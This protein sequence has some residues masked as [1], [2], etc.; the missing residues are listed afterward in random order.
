MKKLYR[1]NNLYLSVILFVALLLAATT[2]AQNTETAKPSAVADTTVK[3]VKPKRGTS[4]GLPDARLNYTPGKI[5]AYWSIATA[6]SIMARY[7]DYREAYWKPWS[8]V[9]G[10]MFYGFEML[11]RTTGD[12]RY[13][14]FIKK[15]IDNFVDEKGNFHGD[16]LNNLDNLMTGSSIVD[17]YGY[18]HA[19]RYKTAATQ[20]R[21]VFD[22]YPRSHDGQ[23]WHGAKS[24]NMW[25]DGVFMG[26]MF[27]IRYGKIIGDSKYCYDEA[28]KQITVCAKHLLKGETGLY[29]HGWTEQPEQAKWADPKT[30]LSPEVWSEGMGWLALVTV[31]LLAEMPN[32]H[33]QYAQIKDIYI[34]L[35][36]GLKR[37]QDKKTG[38]WFMIVDKGD[39]PDNWI[40]PSGTGMF[41]YFIQRGIDI[42]VIRKKEYATVVANGYKSLTSFGQINN[43]G[44]VDVVGGGDGIGIKKDYAT[45]VSYK[46]MTNAKETVGGFLWGTAIVEKPRRSKDS[47]VLPQHHN[48]A[49]ADYTQGKVFILEND[50]IVWQHEAPNSNDLWVLS[51][52]NLLF[53]TG[54]GVLELTRKNDTIFHYESKNEVYAC[55]RLNNGNTFIGECNSGR[56]LEVSPKGKIVKE[57]RILPDSVRDGGHAY[58]RN[59]RRL[60]NG[61]FLVAHYGLKVIREYDE[62]GTMVWEVSVP[63]GPHTAIRLP[64]GNT[65]VSEADAKKDPHVYEFNKEGKIVWEVSNAD[66]PDKPFKFLGGMQ[67]LP[68]GNT[69]IC[70]WLG[71]NNQFGTAPHILEITRDK[72]V[73]WTYS[74]YKDMKTISTFMDMGKLCNADQNEII[75]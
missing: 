46:R 53:T 37:T 26:Q 30:G 43:H 68:N 39:Q 51:N 62:N 2:S 14:D 24:P 48:F 47:S 42:G 64:N 60:D 55:Q 67:R 4:Q 44:L 45:Y 36:N 31:E 35:A 10:Y 58:M 9:H 28:A 25:I 3:A 74:N 56:L 54:H 70:N 1:L 13:L 41:V 59:A 6:E 7:P 52:G 57:V 15:Y 32:S 16:N 69:I 66:L 73:V 63:G 40:D 22:T 12:R 8:Y 65:L 33:P 5:P 18:T 29:L 75:H 20:F 72:K 27:L 61:H 71:H 49:C 50:Q 23:F 19:E 17:L 34:R 38:G 11:Y 21:K